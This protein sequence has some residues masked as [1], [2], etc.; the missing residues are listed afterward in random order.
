MGL[1]DACDEGTGRIDLSVEVLFLCCLLE[2]PRSLYDV[3]IHALFIGAVVD[4][5]LNGDRGLVGVTPLYFDIHEAAALR[6]IDC[7]VKGKWVHRLPPQ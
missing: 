1:T 2:F 6:A 7:I 5:I 3:V 4:A